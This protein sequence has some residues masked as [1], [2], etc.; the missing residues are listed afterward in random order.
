MKKLIVILF[1]VLFISGF[2]IAQVWT[3]NSDFIGK[4]QPHGVV[5]D[6]NGKIWIGYYGYTD[7]IVNTMGKKV[8][9]KPIWVFNSDGSQASFSP[10]KIVTVAA[11]IDTMWNGCRGMSL[12]NNG[13]ILYSAYDEL[14]RINYLTGE[15]MNKAVPKATKSLTE[16][17]TDENG[18]IY[19]G[20]VS[21]GLP[22]TIYDSDF[23][24]YGFVEDTVLKTTQR[25]ILV[26][27]D[28]NSVF[29]GAIYTNPVNGVRE[30][31][32][33]DG[34][35][36]DG[37]YALADTFGTTFNDTGAVVH[38]MWAQCLDWDMNGLMWVGTYWGESANFF[39]GWY[40]LDPTQNWAI[41]DT[42]GHNADTIPGNGLMDGTVTGVGAYFAPRGI[43]FSADGKTAYTNDFDGNITKK[44]TNPNP[45]GPGS[46]PLFTAIEVK[47][48]GKSF[49]EVGFTLKQNYPN[50]FNPT[51]TIPFTVD[52]KQHVTLKVY[53]T[54]GRLVTTL[55]DQ[56]F[57]AGYHEFRFDG[58]QLASGTYF[59]QLTVDGKSL[60][61]Q[62]TLVR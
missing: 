11:A 48:N 35:G 54:T 42:I 8:A 51:T 28:G 10:I 32:S 36:P 38:T 1:A 34:S 61:K 60:T 40:A 13:N 39:T 50:P 44:W 37:Y 56:Q 27:N 16:A 53:D 46:P 43:A 14:W 20:H 5:V 21:P 59:F 57:N 49:V 4:V 45:A 41:V 3:Y 22:C 29:Y 31:R 58:A 55:L 30:F 2:A 19:I 26:S 7:S 6:P 12:D 17:A 23:N 33:L 25:S 47:D 24:P 62:M 18:F 52:K 15:G 9:I